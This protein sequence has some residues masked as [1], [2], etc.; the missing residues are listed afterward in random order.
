MNKGSA[1]M[2]SSSIVMLLLCNTILLL[3][4]GHAF[5]TCPSALTRNN[6]DGR[7]SSCILASEKKDINMF[8]A[9]D[10]KDTNN[11]ITTKVRV[12]DDDDPTGGCGEG[13]YKVEGKDGPSCVFDYEAAAKAFGTADEDELI[14]NADEYWIQLEKQNAARKKFGM[15]PLTPEQYVVLQ[16]QIHSMKEEQQVK[17][18]EQQEKLAAASKKEQQSSLL[19]DFIKNVMQDTCESNYDCTRP[20]VC[21]DFGFKKMCCSAGDTVTRGVKHE[22]EMIPVPLGRPQ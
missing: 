19:Q 11:D 1:R 8:F 9:S 6:N 16:G 10:E 21:C 5:N 7:H 22:F 18:L 13:F 12:C 17:L 3:S 20:E 4:I 2:T 14:D 15:K